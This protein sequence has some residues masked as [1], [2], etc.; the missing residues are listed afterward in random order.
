M[1][2]EKLSDEKKL[3]WS[4]ADI[5]QPGLGQTVRAYIHEDYRMNMHY[6]DFFEL[7]I[8]LSGQG[9]H[10]FGDTRHLFETG[11]VFVI[12]PGARH[13]YLPLGAERLD[14]FH[15][16]LH[17]SFLQ[18]YSFELSGMLGYTMLFTAEPA[19]RVQ[20][21]EVGRYFLHLAKDHLDGLLPQLHALHS[22]YYDTGPE[23][24]AMVNALAMYVLASLCRYYRMQNAALEQSD[25]LN[26]LS[27]S[28][29]YIREHCD[30]KLVTQTLADAAAT[31]RSTLF[32]VFEKYMGQSP[33]K[34]AMECRLD[35]ACGMLRAS[36]QS[37]TEIAQSCGFFDSSHFIHAFNARYGVT[38][39]QYRQRP[40]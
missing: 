3:C 20:S 28:L 35:K 4:Y 21:S 22:Y 34:Y 14:V 29:Q 25:K 32:R 15:I 26:I 19:I 11:D 23:S 31:S 38:P 5:F 37:I 30:E 13:G 39:L 17:E 2:P 10:Y 36:E 24:N 40:L 7:N 27:S 1:Y 18:R 16:L 8:V 33:G 6:H 12:P 9:V